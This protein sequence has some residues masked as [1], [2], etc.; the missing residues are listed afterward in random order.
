MTSQVMP[1]IRSSPGDSDP[2]GIIIIN[3]SPIPRSLP[4]SSKAGLKSPSLRSQCRNHAKIADLTANSCSA[5]TEI[6]TI[7]LIAVV[8]GFKVFS[9]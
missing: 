5:Q 1:G 3:T 8:A 2:N 9:Q 6:E 4:T 7:G